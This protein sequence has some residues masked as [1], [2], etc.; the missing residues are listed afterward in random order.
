MKNEMIA[1]TTAP[2]SRRAESQQNSDGI[3]LG[4]TDDT[5]ESEDDEEVYP[6]VSK[7][8]MTPRGGRHEPYER[9]EGEC[10]LF[11]CHCLYS[12]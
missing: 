5:A 10:F 11:F 4:G 6:K 12:V 2:P 3:G 9:K 1:S 8:K 7:V